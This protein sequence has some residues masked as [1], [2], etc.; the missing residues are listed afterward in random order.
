MEHIYKDIPK[1]NQKMYLDIKS[2]NQTIFNIHVFASIL[3]ISIIT[4][5]EHITLK[6]TVNEANTLLQY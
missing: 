6:V 2:V 4:I 1:L 3:R 5:K